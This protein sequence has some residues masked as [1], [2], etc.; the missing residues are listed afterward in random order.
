MSGKQK[1]FSYKEGEVI[2]T[3]LSGLYDLVVS[4]I[5]NT[6]DDYK[7]H[8]TDMLFVQL[9]IKSFD[10][11]ILSDIKYDDDF[12]FKGQPTEIKKDILYIPMSD[13][14]KYLGKQLIPIYK[15]DLVE[16]NINNNS[17]TI[18]KA[19]LNNLDLINTKFYLRDVV[20]PW[21]ILVISNYT[22][23]QSRR[24]AKQAFDLSGN[25]LKSIEDI[26]F[27]D[28]S[29][30]KSNNVDILLNLNNKIIYKEPR[31]TDINPISLEKINNK[32]VDS[33][34][35]NMKI[36]VIDLEAYYKL[37]VD[38]EKIY[39]G[40]FYTYIDSSPVIESLDKDL[41]SDKLVVSLI[42]KM[43]K[44]K[45]RGVIFY[46]HNFGKYDI[47]FILKILLDYNQGVSVN[48]RYKYD[49]R[50]R[51]GVIL[52]LK[53]SKKVYYNSKD[54]SNKPI[55][56]FKTVSITI[57]DSYSILTDNLD[58][59]CKNFNINKDE[60]KSIFPHDFAT[61]NTLFYIGS[62]P[63]YYYYNSKMSL[64]NY[65]EIFTDNWNFKLESYKYL[66][67]DLLSLY[68]VIKKANHQLLLNFDVNI[69][70]A[71]TISGLANK[72]FLKHHYKKPV[73]PLLNNKEYYNDIKQSYY[74][75]ITEVY[76]PIGFD[77]FYYDVNSLYPF[78][79]LKDMPG[80][81]VSYVEYYLTEQDNIYNLEDLFGFFYCKVEAP[82]DLYIGLL[83]VKDSNS[84]LIFPLGK[85]NGWYF[86]EQLK[87][88]KENGYKIEVIRGYKFNKAKDVFNS[89]VSDIYK[90]KTNK[91]KPELKSV[92]KLILNSLLGRFALKLDKSITQMVNENEFEVIAAT[93]D[94][95]SELK[96][97][98]YNILIS[99][100]KDI[101]V[102]NVKTLNID[103]DK[104][105]S[106]LKIKSDYKY[107]NI[108]VAI[109][110]AITAYGR[111]HISQI[112]IDILKFGGKI[113]YSDTDSI[114]TDIELPSQYVN[115]DKIGRLKLEYEGILKKAYFTS[116]KTYCL[117]TKYNDI[118]KK[119]KGVYN[120]NIKLEDYI[121]MYKYNIT[122]NS[123]TIT[124]IKK[125][126]EGYVK[127]YPEDIDVNPFSYTKRE[128]IFD[129][130]RLWIDTKP[131][132][133]DINPINGKHIIK[134][135]NY[136]TN[137]ML[138]K[139][140]KPCYSIMLYIKPCYSIILY[141]NPCYSIKLYKKNTRHLCC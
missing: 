27:D 23:N 82:K 8:T 72:I 101:N 42:E 13:E 47:F 68:N 95:L 61:E 6:M 69:T 113:Y 31:L 133:V 84:G 135:I 30:R 121:Y 14:F 129:Y 18:N 54:K 87:F 100:S 102:E 137:M 10:D 98:K 46:C 114:V 19:D 97:N 24:S 127:I 99:F 73:I 39:S 56:K 125:Y 92:S 83:P 12:D 138:Y 32:N 89:F 91:S 21:Y 59:L 11:R 81:S 117:I 1:V 25:L 120:D 45:Y 123:K 119:A 63:S 71:L 124:S 4:R 51:D 64:T 57:C 132:I 48:D 76:I 16:L 78:V 40:G 122:V 130:K 17:V 41:N 112:K 28:H 49:Y 3:K 96:F 110:S 90:H 136:Y 33:T 38:K 35:E 74:G 43:F 66:T 55:K 37:L 70:D 140:N 103:I 26:K 20:N 105:Y 80:C 15:E 86:S 53:I 93:K 5:T 118:I 107:N 9:I 29:I 108:S 60:A 36:G 58:K 77:L 88:A 67:K 22:N 134:N 126:N 131:W 141:R 7:I 2:D 116:N 62:T 106:K 79:A 75:G 52:K 94:I 50:F 111:I 85:W 34:L 139:K 104:A 115:T 109:S 44:E 128:K 65:N